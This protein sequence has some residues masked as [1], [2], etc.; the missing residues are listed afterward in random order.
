ML[1]I[2]GIPYFMMSDQNARNMNERVRHINEIIWQIL[3]R[4]VLP[5]R[6]LDVARMM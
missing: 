6:L 4:S 3:Q 5:V 1:T 2:C